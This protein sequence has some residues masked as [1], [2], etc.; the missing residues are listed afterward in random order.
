MHGP[1]TPD[2]LSDLRKTIADAMKP[3]RYGWRRTLLHMSSVEYI[4]QREDVLR[5]IRTIHQVDWQYINPD[6]RELSNQIR[7]NALH[8]LA[9]LVQAMRRIEIDHA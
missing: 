8:A 3:R 1:I 6:N 2:E 4:I 7:E 5:A 9:V